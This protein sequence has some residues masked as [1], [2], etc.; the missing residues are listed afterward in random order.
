MVPAV[1]SAAGGVVPA[2]LTAVMI[3]IHPLA[4]LPSSEGLYGGPR[5]TLIFR[6][7]GWLLSKSAQILAPGWLEWFWTHS[8]LV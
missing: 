3:P 7:V 6:A 5:G 2:P 8:H 4:F 1:F